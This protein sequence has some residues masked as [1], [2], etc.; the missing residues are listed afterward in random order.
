MSVENPDIVISLQTAKD[1]KDN[2]IIDSY[3]EI[4][5]STNA[6]Y[7]NIRTTSINSIELARLCRQYGFTYENDKKAIN[8]IDSFID[9]L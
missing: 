7:A 5:G 4:V 6:V 2:E 8:I 9:S 1:L 3:Q